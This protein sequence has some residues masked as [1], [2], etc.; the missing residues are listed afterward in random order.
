MPTGT[1]TGSMAPT[2]R[3]CPGGVP[4]GSRTDVVHETLAHSDCGYVHSDARGQGGAF[5]LVPAMGEVEG[6][7][8]ESG[9]E[10]RM[11]EP[12]VARCALAGR[13][14][15]PPESLARMPG[16]GVHRSYPGRVPRGFEEAALRI[17]VPGRRD[18]L[19][20]PAPAPAG[21]EC[22]EILRDEVGS[23]SD[24]SVVEG[25]EL[26]TRRNLPAAQERTQQRTG[27]SFDERLDLGVV[28]GSGG[29][30]N[31][32]HV[33][34]VIRRRCQFVEGADSVCRFRNQ[35]RG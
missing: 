33:E 10:F 1:A 17:S 13:E 32:S 14:N 19:A 35:T 5:D 31:Y 15:Q 6:H 16:V 3:G 9:E 28:G 18:V 11:R 12:G 2:S 27:R 8:S 22:A 20:P 23:I 4:R 24:E 25:H 30:Q 21:D 29:A 26:E 34:I 7:A